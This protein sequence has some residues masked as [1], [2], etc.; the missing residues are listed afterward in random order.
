MIQKYFT[1]CYGEDGL[2]ISKF[3]S[4]KEVEIRDN[5]KFMTKQEFYGFFFKEDLCEKVILIKGDIVEPKQ[6]IV[7]KE[8]EE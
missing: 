4:I 3:D 1:I 7:V 2:E 6:K 5:Q 8:W